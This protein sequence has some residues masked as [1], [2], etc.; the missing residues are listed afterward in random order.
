MEISYAIHIHISMQSC[1]WFEH[2]DWSKKGKLHLDHY[3]VQNK[4]GWVGY[5]RIFLI[6]L[7]IFHP[8]FGLKLRLLP[9]V[10]WFFVSDDDMLTLWHI[11]KRY[12]LYC[13]MTNPYYEKKLYRSVTDD[14]ISHSPNVWYVCAERRSCSSIRS[15]WATR[16]LTTQCFFFFVF[17]KQCSQV[18]AFAPRRCEVVLYISDCNNSFPSVMKLETWSKVAWACRA[19]RG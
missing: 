14:T 17:L 12:P 4:I 8:N 11:C 5:L 7:L 15:V 19:K 13:G 16:V 6:K 2:K 10:F 18:Q 3:Q 9:C 1:A